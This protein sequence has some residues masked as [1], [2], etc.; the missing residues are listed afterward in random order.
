MSRRKRAAG[1]W[2]WA[3][4]MAASD[5]SCAFGDRRGISPEVPGNRGILGGMFG[6]RQTATQWP[7]GRCASSLAAGSKAGITG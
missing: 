4:M 3:D 7:D 1:V 5:H 6:A 2:S